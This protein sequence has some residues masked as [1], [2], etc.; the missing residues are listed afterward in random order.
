MKNLLSN[1]NTNAKTS[2]NSLETYILY[3]APHTLNSKGINLCPWASNGCTF[4]CLYTSGMGV[5]SNVQKARIEKS[6]LFVNDKIAFLNKLFK[7]LEKINK[8]AIKE[9]KQIA[10]RLNGTSDIDF[11]ALF[12]HKLN[13]SVLDLF[14]NL[15]F[16]DYTKNIQKIEKYQNENRYHLTFSRSEDTKN[17][18]ILKALNF[19]ANVAIVFSSNNLPDFYLNTRVLNG[20]DSDIVMVY[21]KSKILGLKA[22]GKAKKDKSGFVIQL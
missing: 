9:N 5:F 8:K 20:D 19:N 22:K 6:D 1:G 2:K 3:L 7:E 10:I 18:D 12:S 17:E 14:P 13:K 16:Y 4:N 15:V 21:N 11:V